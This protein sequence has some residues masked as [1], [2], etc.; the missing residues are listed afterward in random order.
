M[1]D[2]PHDGS[3]LARRA[4]GEGAVLDLLRAARE[5]ISVPE[6][7]TQGHIART[8]D[9]GR[10]MAMDPEAA[11]WC[12][13]GAVR[14]ADASMPPPHSDTRL[15]RATESLR[16]TIGGDRMISDWNDKLS[17][18]HAEVLDLFDRTIARLEADHG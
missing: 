4:D 5:R 2:H 7:W 1:R 15:Q 3:I 9:G 18:T 11:M 10:C 13:L 16:N 14:R 17:R 12:A 6:G 8:A